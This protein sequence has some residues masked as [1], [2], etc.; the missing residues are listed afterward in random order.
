MQKKRV[1]PPAVRLGLFTLLLLAL[2]GMPLGAETTSP[3]EPHDLYNPARTALVNAQLQLAESSQQQREFLERAERM[4]KGM[5][6][7]L[8]LLE[9]AGQL[10]PSMKASIDEVRERL[11][12]LRQEASLCSL[13]RGATLDSYNQLLDDLQRLIERY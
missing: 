3:S 1:S 4:I 12:A 6:S 7:S 8:A 2:H 5:D 10:D 11:V 9:N 13:N